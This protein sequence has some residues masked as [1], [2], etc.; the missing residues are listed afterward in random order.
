M[1]IGDKVWTVARYATSYDSHMY[2]LVECRIVSY[3]SDLNRVCV[4]DGNK[5]MFVSDIEIISYKPNNW[6]EE[7]CK[8]WYNNPIRRNKNVE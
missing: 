7:Q 5:L 4:S 2:V 1:K 8:E 6:T 3:E